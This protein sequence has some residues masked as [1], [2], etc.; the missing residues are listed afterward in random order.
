MP[1]KKLAGPVAEGIGPGPHR[2]AF[3]VA[4]D[5]VRQ[6]LCRTVA[7][8]RFLAQRPEDD[9]VEVPAETAAPAFVRHPNP[10][11]GNWSLAGANRRLFADPPFEAASAVPGPVEGAHAGHQLV[12]QDAEGV[13]VGGGAEGFPPHLL[14]ARI[15][16]GQE[17]QPRRRGDG[18]VGGRRRPHRRRGVRFEQLGDA[19]VQELGA[20]LLSH[21]DVAGF[22]VAVDHQVGVGVLDRGTDLQE[23][24]QPPL[25]PQAPASAVDIDG[26]PFDVVHD[27]VGQAF[28][29]VAAVEELGEVGVV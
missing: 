29:G 19:E 12:E 7:P 25:D 17:P 23:E 8:A 1:T 14:G 6:L 22:D 28:V 27:E 10:A 21:Q 16:E 3:E 26:L 9:V 18:E 5:V 24:A 4:T 20:P 2:P 11:G 13:H 15:F